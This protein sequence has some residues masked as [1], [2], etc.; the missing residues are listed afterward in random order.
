[1]VVGPAFAQ[2]KPWWG[3]PNGDCIN[4]D[5][6]SGPGGLIQE[7]RDILKV[8]YQALDVKDPTSDQIVQT[9]IQFQYNGTSITEIFYRGKDRCEAA[10][11]A[12]L[13]AVRTR[14]AETNAITNRYK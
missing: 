4:F 8:P 14:D 11:R 9:A 2:E 10:K 6:N 5:A 3:R 12:S 7:L 1:M 13:D